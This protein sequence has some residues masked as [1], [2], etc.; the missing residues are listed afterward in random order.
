MQ[1]EG[2]GLLIDRQHLQAHRGELLA[3]EGELWSRVAA[4][5]R[6]SSGAICRVLEFDRDVGLSR[7]IRLEPGHQPFWGRRPGRAFPSH[8]VVAERAPTRHLTVW[9]R[10]RDEGSFQVST[11]HPGVPTPREIHDPGLALEDLPQSLAFWSAHALA[12]DG[13]VREDGSVRPK[14]E[15][16]A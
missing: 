6:G 16:G 15:S 14:V 10:W 7:L 13:H 8:L 9:G 12:V 1:V 2:V 3:E 11:V 4:A 5:I